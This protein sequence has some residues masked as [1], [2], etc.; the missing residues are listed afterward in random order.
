M[1]N[2][3]NNLYDE[4]LDIVGDL[5]E[6]PEFRKLDDC[7]HHYGVSRMQHCI[8]VAYYSF[9]VCKKMRLDYVAAAR[10]GLLHD[11]FY[12]DW[13]GSGIGVVK[14]ARLHSRIALKNAEKLTELSDKER[15][16]I[17]NHMWLCGN[18]WPHHREAYIVSVADKLCAVWEAGY[19]V[20]CRVQ[21]SLV[22]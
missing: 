21:Y 20:K 15:D 3:E 6:T 16:I 11:L 10:A 18:I 4:F 7:S 8:N 1:V 14:H 9:V 5:I 22:G 12:Y 13:I 17:K 2:E 19:G